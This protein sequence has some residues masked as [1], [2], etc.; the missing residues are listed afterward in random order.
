ML[1]GYKWPDPTNPE[2][3]V[4]VAERLAMPQAKDKYVHMGWFVGLFDM[5]YR[6]HEFEDCMRDF[7][8][9]PKKMKYIT[10]KVADFILGA[11]DTLASKF[12]GRIHGLL[13]PDDW[14]GQDSTFVSIPMWEEFFG[15]HYRAIGDHL[16]RAGIHFWLHSDG[17]VN[18]LVPV[19]IDC[20][21]DVINLPSPQVVGID[22]IAE[23][24]AGKICFFNG[25]DIQ[26]TL[27]Q[28]SDAEIDE[29][30]RQLAEKWHTP[31][32]GFIPAGGL[33]SEA[34]GITKHRG[35]VAV[36]AFRK[37]CW[38]LPPLSEPEALALAK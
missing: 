16:H 21:L 9:E 35:L 27:V 34:T 14:G 18:N 10:A 30:A 1:D 25:V 38:G 37:Y 32:G 26:S 24:F 5:V 23:R 33:S 29:E 3:Y 22:D 36:N 7:Y 2:R 20:G 13:I 15:P 19:L 8:V 17:R 4:K 31:K 6:L 11:I 28:G 12:P